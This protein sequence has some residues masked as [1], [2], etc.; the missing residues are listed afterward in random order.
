MCGGGQNSTYFVARG[1]EVTG[2]DISEQQCALYAQRFPG[3]RVLC[4]SILDTGLDDDSFDLVFTDSLHH[5]HPRL[6]DGVREFHRVLRP[7]GSLVAWEPPSHLVFAA[8]PRAEL[9]RKRQIQL[10]NIVRPGPESF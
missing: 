3:Q 9:H 8:R 4:R 5:L 6:D 7:S 1:C 10:Q 2:V